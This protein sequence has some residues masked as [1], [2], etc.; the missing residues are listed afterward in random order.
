MASKKVVKKE[1]SKEIQKTISPAQ[2]QLVEEVVNSSLT[3]V[4]ELLTLD[5][6]PGV[7][8]DLFASLKQWEDNLKDLAQNGRDRLLSQVLIKGDVVTAAGTRR[9]EVDGWELEARPQRTGIDSKK[10]EALLRAKNLDPSKHMESVI[11][12]KVSDLGVSNLLKDKLATQDEIE[13]CHY[14][15]AYNLQRPKK[16]F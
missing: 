12:Y 16:V 14:E 9:W 5:L 15:L 6:K 13:A 10:L 2:I 4:A 11:T 7:L 3:K 8:T 1:E